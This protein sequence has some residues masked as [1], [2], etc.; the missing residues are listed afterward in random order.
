[1]I[2]PSNEIARRAWRAQ[3]ERVVEVVAEEIP[4]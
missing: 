3:L 1:M 2:D 4:G